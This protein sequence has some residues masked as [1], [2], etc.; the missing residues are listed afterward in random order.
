MNPGTIRAAILTWA[1]LLV[2]AAPALAQWAWRDDSGRMVYSDRPP[3]SNVP[4]D[5]IVARPREVTSPPAAATANA[6]PRPAAAPPAPTKTAAEQELEFQKR[7][8]QQADAAKKSDDQRAEQQRQSAECERAR[9]YL[10][11]LE[12]GQ[13]VARIDAQG[14]REYLEDAQRDAEVQRAQKSIAANCK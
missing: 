8:Q 12:S 2:L 5:R 3:G 4:A 1:G 7:R 10:R 6:A 13:R 9:G 14:E 11:V